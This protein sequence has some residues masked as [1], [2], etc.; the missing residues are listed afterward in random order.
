M[1]FRAHRTT[2]KRLPRINGKGV[3]LYLLY[4]VVT[5]RGGWQKVGELAT[6]C[7][8]PPLALWHLTHATKHTPTSPARALTPSFSP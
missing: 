3:D 1:V 6:T 7:I 8:F 2:F 5:A 4:V